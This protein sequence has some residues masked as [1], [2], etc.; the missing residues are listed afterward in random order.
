MISFKEYFRVNTKKLNK[1]KGAFAPNLS[2]LN[3]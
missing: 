2:A 3:L 1:K